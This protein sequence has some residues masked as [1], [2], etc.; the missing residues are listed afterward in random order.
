MDKRKLVAEVAKKTIYTK[1]E[2]NEMIDPLFDAIIEA[3]QNGDE[4]TINN[5]GKFA[6][7][8]HKSKE[9]V[10]PTTRKRVTVQEKASV[11]F[12]A[13]RMYKPTEEAM[14]KLASQKSVK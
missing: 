14:T 13:T 2:I 11:V 1:R 4:V 10:H 5:F 7:K 9:T 8:Y 3:L 12:K 6:P